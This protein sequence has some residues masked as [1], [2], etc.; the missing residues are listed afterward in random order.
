MWHVGLR[1]PG[2]GHLD[3]DI[4]GEQL[5]VPA[6]GDCI[7]LSTRVDLYSYY[8]CVILCEELQAGVE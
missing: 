1:V 2:L 6:Q 3:S 4:V 5:L 7:H 8:F